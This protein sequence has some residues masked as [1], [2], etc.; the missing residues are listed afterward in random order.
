[1]ILSST[2]AENRASKPRRLSMLV[3]IAWLNMAMAPC[4]MAFDGDHPCPHSAPDTAAHGEHQQGHHGHHGS[5]DRG[6]CGG[7]ASDCC[8][9]QQVA[10]DSRPLFENHDVSGDIAAAPP[11]AEQVRDPNHVSPLSTG[12]PDIGRNA[13]HPP[14][15]LLNCV[16]LK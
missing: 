9:A 8:D 4:A 6:D 10:T 16:F 15:N 14:L 1:M 12:P 13:T 11:A 5:A 2:I 3:L 7:A